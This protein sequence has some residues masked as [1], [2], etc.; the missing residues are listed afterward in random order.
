M[1]A[2]VAWFMGTL[3]LPS[4][5]ITPRILHRTCQR[6]CQRIWRRLATPLRDPYRPERHYMRGPG[7]K[8]RAKKSASAPAADHAAVPRNEHQATRERSVPPLPH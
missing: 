3:H 1:T 2:F 7:P 4:L 6:T 5:R 8:T